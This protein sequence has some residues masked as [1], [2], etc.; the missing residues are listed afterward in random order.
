MRRYWLV[1]T[2]KQTLARQAA[3]DRKPTEGVL[4]GMKSRSECSLSA[5][6]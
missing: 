4:F 3:L 1:F 2:T 5:L 6:F